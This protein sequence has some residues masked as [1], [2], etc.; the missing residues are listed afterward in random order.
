MS[1][2]PAP[3]LAFLLMAVGRRTRE[4]VEARLAGHGLTYRHLSTLGHLR[5]E[6]E[7]SYSELGRRAGVTAQSMQATVLGLVGLG[8][9]EQSGEGGRGRRARL[10]VTAK[11]R[12]LLAA[13]TAEVEAVAESTAEGLTSE[14]RQALTG[15]LLTVFVRG[16]PVDGAGDDLS[17]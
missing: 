9:V 14:Q 11:G 5:R 4:D 12:R 3:D 13:G 1:G 17:G 16:V 8:A 15:A 6:P 2:P 7:L 10:R